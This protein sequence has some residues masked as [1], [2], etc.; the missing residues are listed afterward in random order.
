MTGKNT[1]MSSR[2]SRGKKYGIGL[3]GYYQV[4][5]RIFVATRDS[6]EGHGPSGFQLI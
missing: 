4:I 2:C 3:P 6:E 5:E 1:N